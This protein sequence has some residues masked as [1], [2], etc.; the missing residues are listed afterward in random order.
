MTRIYLDHNATGPLRPAARDAM[1]AALDL[2]GNPSSVHAHGRASRGVVE[3]ARAQVAGLVGVQS[4]QVVFTSGGTEAAGLALTPHMSAGGLRPT[5]LFVSAGEHPCVLTGGRFAP[6]AIEILP[7]RR[8]GVFDLDA[9][10][11]RLAALPAGEIPMLALQAANNETGVLQPVAEAAALVRARG[12]VTICDAVQAAGRIPVSFQALGADALILSA[13]KFG[14]PKGVGALVIDASQ[15]HIEEALVRGGGQ[16]RGLRGGTENVA[17][18]AGFGAAAKE[19][20]AAAAEAVR[21]SALRDG[22]ER[23][24]RARFADMTFFGD[25]AARLPNTSAFAFPGLS[26]ETLLISLDLAGVSLSSGSACSSGK[27]RPSHVL[28][29]MGVSPDLAKG[30]LRVSM[31]WTTTQA[32]AEGLCGALEKAVS[33]MRTRRDRPAA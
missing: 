32:D 31:G 7:L 20:A 22:M 26:A 19:A 25:E 21:I 1:L 14:G 17:G 11:A 15:L 12:G 33:S 6:D 30:A 28:S 10:R 4:R 29:A 2:V 23:V 18:I 24:L 16:E 5:R 13:H 9:L 8:D 27:V 3:A